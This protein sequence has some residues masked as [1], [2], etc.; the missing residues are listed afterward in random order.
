MLGRRAARQRTQ[1]ADPFFLLLSLKPSKCHPTLSASRMCLDR[2]RLFMCRCVYR[3]LGTGWV[4]SVPSPL[5]PKEVPP[6]DQTPSAGLPPL[7][8]SHQKRVSPSIFIRTPRAGAKP[9]DLSPFSRDCYELFVSFRFGVVCCW[10]TVTEEC[11]T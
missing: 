5:L 11:V 8:R 6:I 2:S 10:K 1:P 9:T 3:C 7:S 4:R